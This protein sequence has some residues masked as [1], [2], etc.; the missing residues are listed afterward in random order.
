MFFYSEHIISCNHTD[1]QTSTDVKTS[2]G[3]TVSGQGI[4]TSEQT[5]KAQVTNLYYARS[6]V[7]LLRIQYCTAPSLFST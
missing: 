3:A 4:K 5:S 1:S 6:N 7:Q 2:H